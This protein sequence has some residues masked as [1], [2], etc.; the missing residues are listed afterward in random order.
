MRSRMGAAFGEDFA[1]VKIH[2][3]GQAGAAAAGFNAKPFAFGSDIFFAP[4]GTSP[5]LRLATS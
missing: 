2:T 3:G 1:D 4:G 5:A